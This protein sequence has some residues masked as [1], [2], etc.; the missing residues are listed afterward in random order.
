M[1]EIAILIPKDIPIHMDWTCNLKS[2]QLIVRDLE[3][4]SYSGKMAM[5][6]VKKGEE[7]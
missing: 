4:L 1:I 5:T 3:I 7:Y 6:L 2:T